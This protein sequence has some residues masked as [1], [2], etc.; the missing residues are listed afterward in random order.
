MTVPIDGL[1]VNR[2]SDFPRAVFMAMEIRSSLQ[3]SI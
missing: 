1:G 3:C 2:K